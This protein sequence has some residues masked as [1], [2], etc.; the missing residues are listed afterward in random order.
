MMA[1]GKISKENNETSSTSTFLLMFTAFLIY[2]LVKISA[3]HIE[4]FGTKQKMNQEM[5]K[6]RQQ[7]DSLIQENE[8][9]KVQVHA[10]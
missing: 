9:L 2:L 6:I 1:Q 10:K 7:N 3:N 4:D 5:C 8:V